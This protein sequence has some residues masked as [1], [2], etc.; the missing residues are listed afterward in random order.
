MRKM[1]LDVGDKRIGVAVSDGLG[2]TAQGIQTIDREG[3]ITKLKKIIEEYDVDSIV[4]GIPRMLNGTIGIQGEKVLEFVD[5]LKD[6]LEVPVSGWDERFSTLSAEK[7]L[8]EARMRRIKRKGLR[9]KISAVLI[10]Q[11]YLDSLE[12]EKNS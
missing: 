8:I 10:L 9:D 2:L 1:G 12:N 6:S 5:E 4:V 3:S 7:T 11:N